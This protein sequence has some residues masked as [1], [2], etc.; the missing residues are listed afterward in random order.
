MI[1]CLILCSCQ[2]N[3]QSPSETEKQNIQNFI[4]QIESESLEYNQFM[5]D[6][7]NIQQNPE[8]PTGCEVTSLAMVLNHLGYKID[9]CIL[10]DDF[11][12]KGEIGSTDFS[13]A[14]AGNPRDDEGYG[15][16]AN[17]IQ[18]C[19]QDYLTSI[20]AKVQVLNLTSTDFKTLLRYIQ[21]GIPVIVW[22]TIDLNEPYSTMEWE[23]NGHHIEWLA[24]E[25]C[26]VLTGYNIT[27]N[28]VYVSDPLQGSVKYDMDLFIK[29]YH[30]LSSQAI[31]II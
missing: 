6:F 5:I 15:C 31:V 8:L 27:D 12:N 2:N 23:I 20:D 30:Q 4:S 17:V 13:E 7:Q 26:V 28:I 21:K 3:R 25:H 14:F 18:E 24:N 11:L 1:F 22:T 19:A 16:Y 9:K 10:A 29:R